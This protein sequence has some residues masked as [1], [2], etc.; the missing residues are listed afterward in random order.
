LR[1]VC[2]GKR[3]GDMES[4]TEGTDPP[5]SLQKKDF[6]IFLFLV[7]RIADHY[8]Q[9]SSVPRDPLSSSRA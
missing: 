5:P 1:R 9:Y 3:Y 8:L 6:S 4:G 7:E 2:G